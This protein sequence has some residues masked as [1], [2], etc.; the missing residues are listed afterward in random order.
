[1]VHFCMSKQKE[2]IDKVEPPAL[3]LTVK[4]YASEAGSEPVKVWLKSLTKDDR[5][6][7]GTD[8]KTV[9]IGWPLG[10]PLIDH[11]GN[12]IWEVRTRLPTQISRV[13]FI[14]EDGQMIL[15]HGFIK[16]TQ[17]TPKQDIELAEDRIKILK[18]LNKQ[19]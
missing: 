17:K 15:L 6:A 1:M 16:K 2:N 11:I 8:I 4:F 13:L 3:K 10:M 19:K 14:I 7:I 18:K 12:G 5:V 9:Q